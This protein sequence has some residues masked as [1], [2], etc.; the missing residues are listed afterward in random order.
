LLPVLL[1][2]GIAT[3]DFYGPSFV[4]MKKFLI[5]ICIAK[6]IVFV[7]V[8]ILCLLTDRSKSRW[9]K[10]G[11]RGVFVTQQNDFSLGLPIFMA[12]YSKTNPEFMSMLFLAAPISLMF[13]N[14][15]AFLMMEY[16]KAKEMGTGMNLKILLK[17]VMKVA[18]S[19][20]VWSAFL[21]LIVNIFTKA[22]LPSVLYESP[23]N[24]G[25]LGVIKSAFPFM[26]LCSLG[27]IIV[28]KLKS[29]KPRYLPV[30]STLIFCKVILMPVVGKTVVD[31][32]GASTDLQAAT[33][34]YCA[35][36]T[37]GGVFP[38]RITIQDVTASSCYCN[39]SLYHCIGSRSFYNGS[40]CNCQH[41][42]T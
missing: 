6:T 14:P 41:G 9:A 38:L 22:T 42:D 18:R 39:G 36:P 33:F 40:S 15:I 3:I 31:L 26:S 4:E 20:I 21:G 10:A 37:T 5:G 7:I 17:I 32:L 23:G 19:P 30:A 13:L 12:L 24:G 27:M 8:V 35:I 11:I 28:G 29:M 16:G 25:W 2:C 34:I 1:F